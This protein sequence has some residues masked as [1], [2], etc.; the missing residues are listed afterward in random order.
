MEIPVTDDEMSIFRS[1]A[2]GVVSAAFLGPEQAS[3][4]AAALWDR[5]VAADLPSP[6][7]NLCAA[8]VAALGHGAHALRVAE[9]IER[10]IP[11]RST[12]YSDLPRQ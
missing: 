5:L 3:I 10:Q 4:A 1:V 8:L 11:L 9:E 6:L 7:G 12:T 2:I